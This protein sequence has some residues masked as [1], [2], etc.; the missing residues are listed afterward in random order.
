MSSEWSPSPP[1]TKL[2]CHCSFLFDTR[3]W[4]ISISFFLVDFDSLNQ[5]YCIEL[6]YLCPYKFSTKGWW[7]WECFFLS[8]Y[9]W[10]TKCLHQGKVVIND[11]T[12]NGLWNS[13]SKIIYTFHFFTG[14]LLLYKANAFCCYFGCKG[15]LRDENINI[16]QR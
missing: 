12:G 15:I 5:M 16:W 1:L 14:T 10:L 9:Y 6:M 8:E 2:A 13:I 3:S 11:S 4:R 7:W